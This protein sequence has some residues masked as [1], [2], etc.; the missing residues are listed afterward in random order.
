M[1]TSNLSANEA[2]ARGI[3]IQTRAGDVRNDITIKYGTNS[4]SEVSATDAASIGLYGNLAQIITTTIQGS[5][6]ATDQAAFYLSLR[7]NPEPNFNSITYAL[8]NPELDDGDRDALIN[9]FMGLPVSI[10]D[11]PL[12]MSSGAIKDSSRAGAF[13]RA[14]TNYQSH[15]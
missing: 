4:S 8:T 10:I 12:N 7:A 9:I 1:A 15:S 5:G 11:L 6:D 2:L 14:I 3:K 13:R